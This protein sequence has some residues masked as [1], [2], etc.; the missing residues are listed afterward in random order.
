MRGWEAT[1]RDIAR[2]EIAR[3]PVGKPFALRPGTLSIT[4]EVIGPNIYLA[5]Q[6]EDLH[7][8]PAA[9]WPERFAGQAPPGFGW[10]PFGGGIRRC[11]GASFAT[12]VA[13]IRDQPPGNAS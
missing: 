2:A 1:V 13:A 7:E 6:R 3:W 10:F 9:F 4:L 12:A 11:L 8:D 5:Q